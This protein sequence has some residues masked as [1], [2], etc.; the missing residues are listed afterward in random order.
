MKR[1]AI[2]R[3]LRFSI[4]DGLFTAAMLGVSETY[5]IPYGIA[6]GASPSQVALLASL[7]PLAAALLQ[8]RSAGVTQFIGSRTR[9][10]SFVV[11]FHALSWLPIILVPYLFSASSRHAA[12]FALLFFVT[13]YAS[14]GAFAVPAWQ[15]L[16]SDT[17]PLQKR[18]RYFGWRN[19]LQGF[20][21]VTFSAAAGLLLHAFGKSK[22]VGFTLLFVFAMFS[23]FAAWGCLTQMAE[24]VRH[25]THDVY[26]SFVDFVKG[27]RTRNFAR[28][29]LFVSLMS[30]AV[31]LSSP[32]LAVFLL[33]DLG[34]SYA[35]YMMLMVTASASGFLFQVRWGKYGDAQGNWKF[36][37]IACWGIAL[38]PLFWMFS[39]HWAYLVVVQ[40]VAG[41]CWGG[42]NLLVSNFLMEAVSPEK[43]IRCISYFN[44]MNGTAVFVGASIGGVLIRHLPKLFG[45][46]Y[47][48]LFLLS[49][50]ARVLVMLFA[51]SRVREVRGAYRP[52]EM[53]YPVVA[54]SG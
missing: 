45:Y 42:F 41:L 26:F 3:S 30:F 13:V 19:G 39:R 7:P 5:L 51:A 21:T 32:L 31:N 4:W 47:L 36:L 11:F 2:R 50:V 24:P 48:A 12:L 44:V 18:G 35:L 25:T 46:S 38:L 15:S 29:V 40:F 43:R 27:I 52:Y 16:M 49:C 33:K 34:F 23:R 1:G 14:F 8:T 20:V 9:L 28:F 37:K 6:L 17:I 54:E 10:I 22:V 53:G